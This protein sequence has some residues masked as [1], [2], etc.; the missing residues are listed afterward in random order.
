M[1]QE[2]RRALDEDDAGED[3]AGTP[4]GPNPD[5][6]G[7]HALDPAAKP[8]TPGTHTEELGGD[9][10]EVGEAGGMEVELEEGEEGEADASREEGEMKVDQ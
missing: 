6:A 5:G 4:E 1:E 2:R 7:P 3:D 8:F 10:A 9:G